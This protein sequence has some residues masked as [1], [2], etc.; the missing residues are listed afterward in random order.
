MYALVEITY[1]YHCWENTVAVSE[2]Y[3]QLEKYYLD[4]HF[5]PWMEKYCPFVGIDGGGEDEEYCEG[6][7]EPNRWIIRPIEYL[8]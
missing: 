1:D 5:D 4:K 3:D 2:S 8:K 7:S 6:K